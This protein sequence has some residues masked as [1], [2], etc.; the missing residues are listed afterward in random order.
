MDR[1]L[2]PPWV[3]AHAAACADGAFKYRD[4]ATGYEVFTEL[5]LRRRGSCCGC[6]CRH[7]PFGHDEVPAEQ[8]AARIRRAAWL[9]GPR[10]EGRD[11]AVVFHSGGKDSYLAL[12]AVQRRHPEWRPVLLTTFDAETRVVAHQEIPIA[13]VVSQAAALDLP[14]MGVPLVRGADYAT[15]VGEGLL[16]MA[17]H[18]TIRTLVFGDLHLRHIRDWRE[19]SLGPIAAQLGATLCFPLWSQPYGPLLD[20][21]EQGGV[22][23]RVSAAPEP[24]LIEPLRVGDLFNRRAMDSLAS[25]VDG[26]GESGEFHT[27]VVAASLAPAS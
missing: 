5:G 1:D 18:A 9:R 10:P 27:E 26:F 13:R 7:C 21:L 23:V 4:P 16:R 14:L 22:E 6:G 8:R 3:R 2:P 24:R 12:R 20:E 11:H 25:E 17:R 15:S 19:R